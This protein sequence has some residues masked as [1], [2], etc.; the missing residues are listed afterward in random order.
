MALGKKLWPVNQEASIL[1]FS[2]LIID[3]QSLAIL[4]LSGL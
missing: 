3:N 2:L 4:N 1:D